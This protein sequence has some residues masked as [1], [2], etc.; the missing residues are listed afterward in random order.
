[1][2]RYLLKKVGLPGKAKFTR[3]VEIELDEK[4]CYGL[5]QHLTE[6]LGRSVCVYLTQD[7]IDMAPGE[8]RT[9]LVIRDKWKGYTYGH[10]TIL[11]D[12]DA[13]VYDMASYR[14]MFARKKRDEDRSRSA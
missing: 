3:I 13:V 1:M 6:I 4:C 5:E 9:L 7:L 10:A 14:K 11:R 2:R 12:D 8:E